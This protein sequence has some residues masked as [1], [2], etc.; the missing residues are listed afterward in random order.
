MRQLSLVTVLLIFLYLTSSIAYAEQTSFINKGGQWKYLDNGSNQASSWRAT[1]FNATSWKTG[2]AQLGYGDGDEA[3]IVNYGGS[4]SNKH[5][6]TYFRYQFDLIDASLYKSLL[7]ELL[8][9][10]GAVVYL[11]GTEVVRDNMPS[12]AISY[13]TKASSA[14]AGSSEDQYQQYTLTASALKNGSNT[15]AVE[16]HQSSGSSSDI[17][18]DLALIGSTDTIAV[19]IERGPYLQMGSHDAMTLRWRTQ[20][21]TNSQVRYGITANNLNQVANSATNTTEHEIRLTGLSPQTFYYYSIGSSEDVFASGSSY[22]FETSP[23]TGSHEPIRI[24]VIGD[25]GTANSNAKAVYDAYKNV[26]G[27]AYTDL[28]LML[29]DNAYQNGTDSEYQQAVFNM[30][31]EILRQTPLWSTLGNHD[32]YSST[33]E[34]TGPY[35][36][37]F[38]L[39]KQ[40]EVGGV[41]SGRE[42]YYSFDHANIHFVVLDSF[43][44]ISSSLARNTMMQ[45]L[46]TDL[47]NTTADWII[48]FWHHPPYSKGSHNSDSDSRMSNIRTMILP[49]LENYGVDLVLSGHSH[50]YERSKFIDGH[51]G[52]ASTFNSSHEVDAGSGRINASGAYHKDTLGS[53]H[54]GTVYVVAGSSGKISSSGNLNHNA[55]F[56]SRRELGSMILEVE[57]LTLNAS[58]L[59]DSG[60]K[61]DYFTLT[62]G[63]DSNTD[64]DNDGVFDDKDNCI[65]IANPNQAN[66]DKDKLGNAC[67]PDD[68]NDGMPDLYEKANNFNPLDSS[69]AAK[70]ADKDGYSNLEEYQAKTDPND[71]N[72]VP[73]VLQRLDIRIQQGDDDVEETLSTGAINLT[74]SDLDMGGAG[75][76]SAILIGLRFQ[77]ISIPI[78]SIVTKAYITFT[79][80]DPDSSTTTLT[81]HGQNSANATAFSSSTHNVSQR[82]KTT[83]SITWSVSAWTKSVT[84]QTP[85]LVSLV[86]EILQNKN[87]SSGNAM[88]FTLAGSGERDAESYNGQAGS[89]ALLHIEWDKDSDSDGIGDTTDNCPKV[90]NPDQKDT[91]KDGKGNLCD[92]NN[93]LNI[94]SIILYV[95]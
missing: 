34:E 80:D 68:D 33:I 30:Y 45:W 83:A 17:S 49:I 93:L 39:P 37:I 32:G 84:Y 67:D 6:T 71:A 2:T 54:S 50:A 36:D 35:Y 53:S 10:D 66:H 59:N 92:S 41:A 65:T 58:F 64:T 25:S 55:M 89:A 3:T 42:A 23:T 91:D 38:S 9:D 4:S 44:S 12:G 79:A 70:D 43:F 29:G 22:K 85:S 69:D 60:N 1:N 40:A 95:L 20:V 51:Y 48:A 47:Q 75:T 11:N 57:G 90:A 94:I 76:S 18:F 73:S 5:I 13:Q 61:S 62:K 77:N 88:V 14:V 52:V 28:W 8:R 46:E 81:L 86:N 82:T 56:L 7:L 21:A 72:S 74:S 16:I 15:L 19:N 31:P 27:S 78:G 87:W 63:G 24:W 26:T